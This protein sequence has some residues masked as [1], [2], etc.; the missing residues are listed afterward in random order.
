MHDDKL[1]QFLL[2]PK[3]DWCKFAD[4]AVMAYLLTVADAQGKCEPLQDDLAVATGASL[5]NRGGLRSSIERLHDH[6]WIVWTKKKYFAQRHSYEIQ[7]DNL[8]KSL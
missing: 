8:P 1:R 2:A 3:P 5:S 6:G 7:F 4:V